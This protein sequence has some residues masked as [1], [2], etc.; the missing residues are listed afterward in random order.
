MGKDRKLNAILGKNKV[1]NEEI[2]LRLK[3]QD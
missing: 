1:I 3:E 2:S